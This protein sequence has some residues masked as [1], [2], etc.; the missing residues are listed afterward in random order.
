MTKVVGLV[1]K[2]I[3]EKKWKEIMKIRDFFFMYEKIALKQQHI[4]FGLS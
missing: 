2:R 1:L 4:H 3:A